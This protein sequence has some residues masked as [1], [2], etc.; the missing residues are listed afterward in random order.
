[1]NVFFTLL[2]FLLVICILSSVFRENFHPSFCDDLML[3]CNHNNSYYE[4][5]QYL[6]GCIN[7]KGLKYK[8]NSTCRYFYNNNCRDSVGDDIGSS[9]DSQSLPVNPPSSIFSLPLIFLISLIILCIII[10]IFFQ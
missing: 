5:C 8:P 10:V 9:R 1:M 7:N 3:D 2:T 4:D 6:E